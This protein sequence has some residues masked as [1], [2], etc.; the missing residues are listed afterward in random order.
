M[1]C[2][3]AG[4]V[5]VVAGALASHISGVIMIEA[6][7][8]WTRPDN[9]ATSTLTSAIHAW[10]Q[11]VQ[12]KP[13][14]YPT[15]EAAIAK[16]MQTAI[17]APGEQYMSE[18][19]ARRIV[20]R[21]TKGVDGGVVFTHDPRLTMSS[22]RS[23]SEGQVFD[24]LEHISSP[25]MLVLAQKGWPTSSLTFSIGDRMLHVPHLESHHVAGSHHA[26]A[27]PENAGEICKLVSSF[28]GKHTKLPSK[29]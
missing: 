28:L 21:G 2:G 12:R 16:R 15:L 17:D 11:P 29:L 14:V 6:L 26:H 27:D 22:Y 24:I 19:A 13:K 25:A 18:D 3:T 8:P 10:R 23:M 7:G 4:I 9:M 20:T 1:Q 5:A